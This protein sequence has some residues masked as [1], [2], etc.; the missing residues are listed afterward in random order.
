MLLWRGVVVAISISLSVKV[1]TYWRNTIYW[2]DTCMISLRPLL[3]PGSLAEF[4]IPTGHCCSS[5]MFFL[6]LLKGYSRTAEKYKNYVHGPQIWFACS[7]KPTGVTICFNSNKNRLKFFTPI[8]QT[9]TFMP[10][11]CRTETDHITEISIWKIW[12]KW[13]KRSFTLSAKY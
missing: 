7:Y 13:R 9:I 12:R 6:N 8:P 3:F 11:F 2:K 10:A 1:K 4:W 5:K